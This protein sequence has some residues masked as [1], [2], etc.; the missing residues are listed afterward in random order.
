MVRITNSIDIDAPAHEVYAALRTVDAFPTWLGNSMVYHGTRTAGSVADSSGR[1][2]DSTMLGRMR[3][4]LIE[5]VPDHALQFHQR[6]PSGS[7]DA[8]IRYDIDDTGT[9]THLT[10]V[11]ELTTHGMLRAVQPM[12]VRMAAA[13]SART[14]TA[15]KA[16]VEAH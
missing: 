6:R 15:L 5:D 1:Y 16:H 11:G 10:R 12:L 2:E 8:F 4:E 13:E 3:G 7:L 14:M 9:G